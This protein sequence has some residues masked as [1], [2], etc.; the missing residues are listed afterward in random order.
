MTKISFL[1]QNPL[2]LNKIHK[3][4]INHIQTHII[5]NKNKSREKRDVTLNVVD[6]YDVDSFGDSM[7]TLVEYD[8][9]I[10]RWRCFFWWWLFDKYL[11]INMI[12]FWCWFGWWLVDCMD[13]G[14]W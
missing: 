7:M 4:T 14:I 10:M 2:I 12:L 3:K 5:N 9:W 8:L 1:S 11:V 13:V 6:D